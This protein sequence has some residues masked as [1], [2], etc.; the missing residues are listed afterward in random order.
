MIVFTEM[1]NAI[2]DGSNFLDYQRFYFLNEQLYYYSDGINSSHFESKPS[3]KESGDARLSDIKLVVRDA[4]VRMVEW[5][6]NL[7]I[8]ESE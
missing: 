6:S 8:K 2:K 4:F 1:D 7:K 3:K 5:I